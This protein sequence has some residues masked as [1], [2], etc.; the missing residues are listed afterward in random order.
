MSNGLPEGWEVKVWQDVLEIRS[1]RNQKDVVNPEGKYPILGSA[2][3]VMGYADEFI[4]EAGT[5]IIGR[6]GTIDNPIQ[7]TENFWNVDTAFGLHAKEDLDQKY[8]FYFCK[9]F[10]FKTMDKGSGRPSL[11]KSDLLKIEMPLPSIEIQ[12]DIVKKIDKAFTAIDKAKAIIERNIEN[13]KELFQSKL[14]EIYSRNCDKIIP[15]NELTEVKDGTHNSPKYVDEAIGVPFVTQKNILETGL[16]FDN[17]KYISYT[18]HDDFYRRS[19][20]TKNDIIISMIGA[21]R[22]MSCIVDNS[23]VFSIKNVGLIKSNALYDKHYLLFYLKSSY[24]KK[25]VLD[26][27][28]GSAQGFLSLT[29][30]RSLPIPYTPIENQLE[31][32]N[33]IVNIKKKYFLLETNLKIKK[34]NL[35]ELKKSILQKAF[36]GE[37]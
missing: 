33:Q 23:T 21:N 14:N 8:L 15:L 4:C 37:L 34:N 24:A 32:T 7:I 5:T 10:D 16:S 20:V 30:L 13:A 17:T 28:S 25:Y 22:G 3:K 29:N 11:V 9:G 1:G 35:N 6:K 26:N 2:G 18:D 31:I 19:N 12:N 36:S 27:T